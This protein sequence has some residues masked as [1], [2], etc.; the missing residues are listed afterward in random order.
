MATEWSSPNQ[1]DLR[2][3]NIQILVHGHLI[4]PACSL[5]GSIDSS[6]AKHR[7]DVCLNGLASA[8][9]NAFYSCE[10]VRKANT[11]L[12]SRSPCTG[13]L[14]RCRMY[15]KRKNFFLVPLESVRGRA[16]REALY[17]WDDFLHNLDFATNLRTSGQAPVKKT[18]QF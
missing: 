18:R 13:A 6:A 5:V 1:V 16:I 8:A 15:S 7:S 14:E 10:N 12:I 9:C 4:G 2:P 3:G 17:G 11:R